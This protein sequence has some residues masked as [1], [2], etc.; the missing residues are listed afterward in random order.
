MSLASLHILFRLTSC[1]R[2]DFEPPIEHFELRE[3]IED[4]FPR[5]IAAELG[6]ELG[7]PL[8]ETELTDKLRETLGRLLDLF[9]QNRTQS[10]REKFGN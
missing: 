6:T 1:L 7:I 10:R 5:L 3:F 9:Q 2:G 8:P 4:P